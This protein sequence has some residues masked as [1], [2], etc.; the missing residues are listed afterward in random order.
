MPGKLTRR[1][2]LRRL[3][4]APVIVPASVGLT[5][6]GLWVPEAKAVSPGQYQFWVHGTSVQVENPELVTFMKRFAYGT[7]VERVA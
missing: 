1:N 7:Y 3:S 4:G 5:T 2:F 6:S